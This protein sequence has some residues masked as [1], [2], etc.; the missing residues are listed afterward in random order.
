MPETRATLS[1]NFRHRTI[2]GRDPWRVTHH[3]HG[4][5]VLAQSLTVL[6]LRTAASA[7]SEILFLD[8][9]AFCALVVIVI[10]VFSVR[11]A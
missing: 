3:G 1:A 11:L 9:V 8:I 7:G 6:A 10:N 4:V 5:N 2:V